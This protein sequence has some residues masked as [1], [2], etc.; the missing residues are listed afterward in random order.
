MGWSNV[1]FPKRVTAADLKDHAKDLSIKIQATDSFE[2]IGH[3]I[4]PPEKERGCA[5]TMLSFTF[6]FLFVL[7]RLTSSSKGDDRPRLSASTARHQRCVCTMHAG[8]ISGWAEHALQIKCRAVETM[9][10]AKGDAICEF[11]LMPASMAQKTHSSALSSSAPLKGSHE[12][13]KRRDSASKERDPR[14]SSERND[15]PK[16]SKESEKRATTQSESPSVPRK[17]SSASKKNTDTR[18]E[19]EAS[20]GGATWKF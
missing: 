16:K 10:V 12:E 1:N 17:S 15:S 14:L 8:F 7:L 9:C 20:N 6:L 13:R 11:V 3:D 2:L 19:K 4:A 18:K 5:L